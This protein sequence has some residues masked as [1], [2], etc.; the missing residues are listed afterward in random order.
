MDFFFVL[1]PHHKKKTK[2]NQTIRRFSYS[3]TVIRNL[4]SSL[5]IMTRT[6][7]S[8]QQQQ[9]HKIY[10][11]KN[12][13]KII[14]RMARSVVHLLYTY[15]HTHT[16]R[17]ARTTTSPTTLN[18]AGFC[19]FYMRKQNTH[20][21]THTHLGKAYISIGRHCMPNCY[22]KPSHLEKQNNV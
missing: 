14:T 16:K 22:A 12:E 3:Y 17:T 2:F 8:Q 7:S 9:P 15:T 18:T 4:F 11:K 5:S 20:S 21:H 1:F 13:Q 6:S 19:L 10:E